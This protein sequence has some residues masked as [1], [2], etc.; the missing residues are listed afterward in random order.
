MLVSFLLGIVYSRI[1]QNASAVGHKLVAVLQT[2]STPA[3]DIKSFM[4][5]NTWTCILP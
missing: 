3:C 2:A 1:D 5:H 4:D